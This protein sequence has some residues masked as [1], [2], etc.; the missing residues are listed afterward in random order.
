MLKSIKGF[1]LIKQSTRHY[2]FPLCWNWWICC[3]KWKYVYFT[4]YVFP[5]FL[6][7]FA[8]SLRISAFSIFCHARNFSTLIERNHQEFFMQKCPPS[9]SLVK[10]QFCYQSKLERNTDK[11]NLKGIHL[12]HL[13]QTHTPI[14]ERMSISI[15]RTLSNVE[16]H[17]H[18]NICI[19]PLLLIFV[20]FWV[21]LVLN[22][23]LILK[24]REDN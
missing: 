23:I 21:F 16:H 6:K 9:I 2:Y 4:W 12:D 3:Y 1:D 19:S 7:K 24:S 13:T 5:H 8:A 14:K 22:Q 20:S 15:V 11:K 17:I 18:C 10:I